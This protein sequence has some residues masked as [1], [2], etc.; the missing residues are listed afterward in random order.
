VGYAAG[1]YR[2][3]EVFT[4]SAGTVSAPGVWVA[5]RPI[6]SVPNVNAPH[7]GAGGDAGG[8]LEMDASWGGGGV[9]SKFIPQ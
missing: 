3:S 4:A 1:M 7:V 5:A 2:S 8:V 6:G 9:G